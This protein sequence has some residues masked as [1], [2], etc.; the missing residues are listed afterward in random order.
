MFLIKNSMCGYFAKHPL[1]VLTQR[2]NISLSCPLFPRWIPAV[3][4]SAHGGDRWD[5]D[6]ADQS[7]PQLHSSKVQPLREGPEGESPV[8]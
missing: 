2:L 7:H 8:R 3:S 1:M 5:E 6:G 4:A